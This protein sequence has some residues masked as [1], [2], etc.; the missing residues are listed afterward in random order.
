MAASWFGVLVIHCHVHNY[1]EEL[2]EVNKAQNFHRIGRLHLQCM[3]SF[4][5]KVTGVKV[6]E[7]YSIYRGDLNFSDVF[8]T[9]LV[10]D[11]KF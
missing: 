6:D 7:P 11:F 1:S 5:K 2:R 8:L 9:G 10:L 4:K 3:Q